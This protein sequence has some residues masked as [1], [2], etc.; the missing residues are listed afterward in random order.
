MME[1]KS[2]RKKKC[3]LKLKFKYYTSEV[4]CWFAHVEQSNDRAA[5][6]IYRRVKDGSKTYQT[7]G[8]LYF[9]GHSAKSIPSCSE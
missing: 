1:G 6:S 5:E 7:M 8:Q 9:G 4:T 2:K 3:H